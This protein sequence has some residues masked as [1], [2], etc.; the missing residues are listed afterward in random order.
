M[1]SPQIVHSHP[2][3]KADMT[4]LPLRARRMLA[5]L[6][7]VPYSNPGGHTFTTLS[8]PMNEI[9]APPR[10]LIH[11]VISRP[12]KPLML[13]PAAAPLA[14][15][16]MSTTSASPSFFVGSSRMVVRSPR[17]FLFWE[18][19]RIFDPHLRPEFDVY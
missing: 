1:P 3:I 17:G 7:T 15:T 12:T 19:V 4:G 9:V 18:K 8:K 5:A 14:P 13:W 16:F 10:R 6:E 2:P 11:S